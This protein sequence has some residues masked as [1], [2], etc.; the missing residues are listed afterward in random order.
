MNLRKISSAAAVAF[1]VTFVVWA[2]R[3]VRGIPTSA[4]ASINEAEE[5]R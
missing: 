3:A 4:A 1:V 5:Y 2:F